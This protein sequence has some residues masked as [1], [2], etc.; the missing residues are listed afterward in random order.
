[1]EKQS[2]LTLAEWCGGKLEGEN[3]SVTDVCRNT[4]ALTSGCLFTPLI[5]ARADG[6]IYIDDALQ[7]G[8]KAT[9]C[10]RDDIKPD[11]PVIR[12]SD[13]LRAV[14]DIAT[15][16]RKNFNI[17]LIGVTGSVGKT[18][19][20]R[21]ISDVLK[22]NYRLLKTQDDMNGQVG[23]PYAL[24]SL[25]SAHEAAVMEMGMSQYGELSRL[26]SIASPDIAVINSIGTAHIE[27]FETREN[28]LKAKLEIL[29]GLNPNGK[30]I[31][32]GDEKLL[33]NLNLSHETI[34]Y[35]IENKDC[36]LVGEIITSDALSQT[37]KVKGLGREFVVNLPVGGKH[38][39]QNALAACAV[40]ISMGLCDENIQ[41]GLLAY[42]SAKGRQRIFEFKKMT[43]IDD[44]YNASPD[45]VC[46]SLKILASLPA[47]NRI[48][49]LGGMRELGN[50]ANKAHTLCG[51]VAASCATHLLCYG[52][53]S[54]EYKNGAIRGGMDEKNVKVFESRDEMAEYLKS[55]ASVGD[56][57]LF[58]GS[59]SMKIEEV[60]E[61]FMEE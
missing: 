19:T 20:C 12:V 25:D 60:L 39:A 61:K 14:Q 4:Q 58:K 55:I 21:M 2:L 7:K 17:K 42:E 10:A 13:T 1:M 43:L 6:H 40:G 27:F 45:A 23:L 36:D 9:L 37:I 22:T 8:A 33:W 38:N 31:L 53:G 49:V 35:G 59:H 29:E 54:L 34:Y 51:E 57:V 50:Y 44:C 52:E 15:N 11:C 5:G 47:Q 56:A 3:I 46:A 24:L 41:N 32:C 16:Y 26:T 28:I 18:T 48:A 30:A